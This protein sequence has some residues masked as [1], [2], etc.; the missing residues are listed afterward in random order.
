MKRQ[1]FKEQRG[2]FLSLLSALRKESRSHF[3]GSLWNHSIEGKGQN[4]Y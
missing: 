3:D 2:Y 4:P 1:D